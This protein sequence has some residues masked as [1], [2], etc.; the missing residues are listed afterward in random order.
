MGE[1]GDVHVERNAGG[2]AERFAVTRG[3]FGDFAWFADQ[4]GAP[5]S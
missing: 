1:V 5:I 3:F 2:A 4:I